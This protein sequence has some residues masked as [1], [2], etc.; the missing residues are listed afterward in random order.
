VKGEEN[1]YSRPKIKQLRQAYREALPHLIFIEKR[2]VR[3]EGDLR[4][5][6]AL[7]QLLLS[8]KVPEERIEELEREWLGKPPE[9]AIRK[10][11]LEGQAWERVVEREGITRDRAYMIPIETI[12]EEME[13]IEK[14]QR[15]PKTATNGGRADCQRIV[16]EEEL[17][18][19][20]AEGWRVAAVLPS[21]KVVVER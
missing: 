4:I 14:E 8:G 7:D 10:I 12:K 13:E 18:S 15:R 21:G 11:G 16:G 2:P 3:S 17:P 19:F 9:I 20:L 1:P 6:A 5:K